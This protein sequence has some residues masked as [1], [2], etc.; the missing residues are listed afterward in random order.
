MSSILK[1]AACLALTLALAGPALAAAPAKT[2]P[3]PAAKPAAGAPAWTI[4]K[5]TS[6][7]RFKSAFSGTAFEGGF[8]RWD[9]QINF[10]PKNL[11]GSKAVVTID[12]ASAASGDADRDQTLPTE[13]WFNVAKSPRATFTTGAIRSLGGDRYQAAGTL[14]LKGVSRPVV[15]PFTLAITGDQ[16]KMTGT[17]VLNRSQ[18]NVGQGQFSGADTVPFEVTVTVTVNAKRAK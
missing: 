12:L 2:A 3:A 18:F 16:A 14:N 17:T 9:A 8:S 13:E 4:D 5:A 11:A 6:K 1:P 10:D 15:L 7:I